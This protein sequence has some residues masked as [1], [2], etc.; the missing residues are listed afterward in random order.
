MIVGGGP[1]QVVSARRALDAT[2]GEMG[3]DRTPALLWRVPLITPYVALPAVD[4]VILVVPDAGQ[5][6]TEVMVDLVGQWS[7]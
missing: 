3:L 4:G 5:A 2:V 1:A 6:S 7:V